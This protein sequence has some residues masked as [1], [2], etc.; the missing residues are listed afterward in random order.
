VRKPTPTTDTSPLDELLALVA[1]DPLASAE[2]R[3]WAR[4]LREGERA[5]EGDRKPQKKR[6]ARSATP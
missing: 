6:P 3:E 2:E 4:R 1:D 5:Q